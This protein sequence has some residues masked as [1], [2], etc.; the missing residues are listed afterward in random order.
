MMA[1]GGS[2]ARSSPITGINMTP[3]VDIMLVLLIIFMVTAQLVV[4]RQALTVELPHARTGTEV[5]DFF[6]L[7]I[8]ASGAI[9]L[10]GHALG[11]DDVLTRARAARA[12]NRD[13]RAVIAA[14][15]GVVHGRVLRLMDLLRQAGVSKIG[16]AVVPEVA[17]ST[18]HAPQR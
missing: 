15:A 11:D 8:D 3:L 7:V 9:T 16:F 17:A 4:S 2:G 1:H 6:N 12:K 10:D 14:D 18:Q 13:L 5:P